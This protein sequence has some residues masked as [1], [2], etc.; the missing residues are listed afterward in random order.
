MNGPD[1]LTRLNGGHALGCPSWESSCSPAESCDC[2]D[3]T[4]E[5]DTGRDATGADLREAS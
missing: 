5:E 4:R 3:D 1:P 2:D